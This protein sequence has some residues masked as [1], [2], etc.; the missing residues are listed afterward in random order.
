MVCVVRLIF[1]DEVS[2]YFTGKIYGVNE[3]CCRTFI[4]GIFSS[5]IIH[6]LIGGPDFHKPGLY[7]VLLNDTLR[8]RATYFF[9]RYQQ[10]PRPIT[11]RGVNGWL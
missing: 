3:R 11:G 8:Y 9:G 10:L 1:I 4:D 7:C 2:V 6:N 5:K